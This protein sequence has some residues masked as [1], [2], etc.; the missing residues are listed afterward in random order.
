MYLDKCMGTW[1]D[2]CIGIDV[3]VDGLMDRWTY[4]YI[5]IRE[6]DLFLK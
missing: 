2:M 1:T 5:Y 6:K 4:I 3:G